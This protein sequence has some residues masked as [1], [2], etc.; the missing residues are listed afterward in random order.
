MARERTASQELESALSILDE[1]SKS[2]EAPKAPAPPPLPAGGLK[3][4]GP[5]EG[6]SNFPDIFQIEPIPGDPGRML[7]DEK[8]DHFRKKLKVTEAALQAARQAW[9]IREREFDALE[10]DL[11]EARRSEKAAQE[12]VKTLED[13]LETKKAEI[14][15]YSRNVARAFAQQQEQTESL[16]ARLADELEEAARLK[17]EAALAA[18]TGDELERTRTELALAEGKVEERDAM[19]RALQS[20]LDEEVEALRASHETALGELQQRVATLQETRDR[21]KAALEKLESRA[22]LLEQG[23]ETHIREATEAAEAR[24]R[25][26]SLVSALEAEINEHRAA[27]DKLASE[28]TTPPSIQGLEE[29]DSDMVEGYRTALEEQAA[30][31]ERL[32]ESTLNSV[33]EASRS[34]AAI[35]KGE[36]PP[37][38]RAKELKRSLATLIALRDQLR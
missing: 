19:V 22:K 17:E 14:D 1:A 38:A 37:E 36:T 27:L 18:Q 32:R 5:Y 15:E 12:R 9:G 35:L 34:L 28:A 29:H 21:E 10:A 2:A 8:V 13:F 16:Q 7:P 24:D 23:R 26:L 20:E 30:E 6:R 25:A 31:T 33:A 11:A 4:A 3:S